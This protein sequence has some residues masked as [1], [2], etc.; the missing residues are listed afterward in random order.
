MR[1]NSLFIPR[2]GINGRGWATEREISPASPRSRMVISCNNKEKQASLRRGGSEHANDVTLDTERST[3]IA[4]ILITSPEHVCAAIRS[5][6]WRQ[7]NFTIDI[8]W[9]AEFSWPWHQIRIPC[10]V[11]RNFNDV[12]NALL[13]HKALFFAC[14]MRLRESSTKALPARGKSIKGLDNESMYRTRDHF[15]IICAPVNFSVNLN[16]RSGSVL[17]STFRNLISRTFERLSDLIFARLHRWIG[18][19]IG[20]LFSNLPASAHF[21]N[22]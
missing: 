17:V 22:S 7:A 4:T 14:S 8:K 10:C 3:T 13:Q 21:A 5:V 11:I 1:G 12:I 15:T 16:P 9:L 18:F 6:F 20:N 19:Q 2:L